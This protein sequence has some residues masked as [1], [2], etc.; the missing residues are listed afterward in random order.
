MKLCLRVDDLGLGPDK[1]PDIGLEFAQRCHEEMHGLPYLG[2]VIPG[3]IGPAG[4]RWLRSRPV[5]LTVA[6][7]GWRHEYGPGGVECEFEG[8]EYRECRNLIRHGL[9]ILKDVPIKDFVPPWNAAPPN[10]IA[11]CADERISRIWGEPFRTPDPPALESTSYGWFIPSWWP[12]YG[13]T[14]WRMGEDR[15]PINDALR[16]L[17]W[18]AGAAVVTLHVTW[19]AAFSAKLDG[20]KNFVDRFGQ[21]L[22]SPDQLIR[23]YQPQ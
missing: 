20:V 23:D 15:I 8:M 21:C 6:L 1:G 9:D 13:A 18:R 4:I 14:I 10:L 11:A 7:H 17:A 3:I 12:L 5:G 16:R 19:E 2:G 22:I